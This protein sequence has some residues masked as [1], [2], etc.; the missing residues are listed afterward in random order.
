MIE[1]LD[2]LGNDTRKHLIAA[3]FCFQGREV[4]AADRRPTSRA[5]THA[6]AS[7]LQHFVFRSEKSEVLTED[8]QGNEKRVE[9]VRQ[10]SHNLVKKVTALLEAPPGTDAE[11][12]LVGRRRD[13]RAHTFLRTL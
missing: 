12:R 10:V 13:N 8:Q 1:E 5:M 11:K 6:N 7:L 2:L 3:T 4:G 9:V